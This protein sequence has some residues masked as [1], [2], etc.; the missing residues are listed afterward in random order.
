LEGK[1]SSPVC[2]AGRCGSRKLV[3][4]SYFKRHCPSHHLQEHKTLAATVLKG[5]L[6]R[7]YISALQAK[8]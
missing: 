5:D 7:T 8:L 4:E 2:Y 6:L 3:N 1:E